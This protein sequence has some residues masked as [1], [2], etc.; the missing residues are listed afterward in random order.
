MNEV[1][2]L[3]VEKREAQI[4]LQ[5]LRRS[6]SVLDIYEIKKDEFHIYIPVT[7]TYDDENLITLKA[8]PREEKIMPSGHAGSFDLI[9]QIAIIHER[10]GL[11]RETIVAFIKRSKPNIKTIYLDRGIHGE[12]RL[13][14]LE[15]LHGED[16]SLTI[17]KENNITMKVDVK[18][19][20]FSPRLSTERML[21]AKS[22]KDGERIFDMFCGIGPITLNI[23][24]TKKC[25]IFA[26]DI[27]ADAIDLM[28]ENLKANKLL[29]SVHATVNDS[30]RELE[31]LYNLDRIIMNNPVSRYRNIEIVVSKLK[32]G[33]KLNIYFVDDQQG[34]GEEMLKLLQ[35][36]LELEMKRVVHG[37]SSRMAMYSLQYRRIS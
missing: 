17:Y 32:I 7:P 18:K 6:G 31:I 11:D 35:Y 9:G 30:Y 23:G 33:G 10:R 28:S 4:K 34:I 12:M 13:R 21:L 25:E 3:K 14:D 8:E 19:A 22:V 15:I 27:N 37:Y 2:Y 29:S 20:Y 26:C 5:D 16:C 24:K 36:G 1:K